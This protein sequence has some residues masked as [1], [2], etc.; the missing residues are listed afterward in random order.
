MRRNVHGI[1]FAST[2][3]AFT[4]G[5]GPTVA[6][7]FV[8]LRP[9]QIFSL[10]I[11]LILLGLGTIALSE[12]EVPN[13][14]GPAVSPESPPETID[15]EVPET[16]AGPVYYAVERVVDGDTIIVQGVLDSIRLIG[17]DTPE[18]NDRRPQVRCLAK[19][20]TQR[21]EELVG[22]RE[23]LLIRDVEDRD[24]YHRLLRYVF[25]PD[26]TFVNS[27]IIREGY[28]KILTIPPNVRYVA[29]FFSEQEA[30]RTAGRGLWNPGVCAEG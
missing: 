22:N 27:L 19:L 30:A 9:D 25:L 11:V 10:G 18:V 14:S 28:A 29:R 17:I 6:G 13:P 21:M 12:V 3:H 7:R 8:P 26:G 2:S 23:V 16:L 15:Q 5:I 24:K 20:A 4:A 1:N